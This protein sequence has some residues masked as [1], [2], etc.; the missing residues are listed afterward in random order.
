MRAGHDRVAAVLAGYNATIMAYGQTGSGK[1]HTMFGPDE[2]LSDFLSCDPELHGIVPRASEQLFEG[3]RHGAADS[4]FIVQCSYVEVYNDRLNDLLGSKQNLQ[5]RERPGAGIVVEGLVHEMVTGSRELMHQLAKGNAKRVVAAMKMNPRSSRGHAIFT[6]YVKEIL[7]YGGE[8][9][10]KLNLVD[11]AGMESSKKSYAMEGAS[12]HAMRKEEAKNINTSLYALGTVIE[13][14]SEAGKTGGKGAHVPYRDSKLTRLLQDSLGGNS[15][16]TIVV[17]LRIEAQNIEETTNTLRFAQRA[18]AVKTI[19][20]DNT[21][22]VKDTTKLLRE[23][24][25]MTVQLETAQLMVR[26][27]KQE[28]SKSVATTKAR[29]CCE[30]GLN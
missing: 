20:K 25:E 3:L 7:A 26:Q 4:S 9:A 13:K 8:K 19:V 10:G 16:S 5:M 24:D 1:T 27:L 28:L 30:A 17:T 14:L 18:K 11:L 15:K 23:I 2:V 6:V 21:I 29:S 22:S 12:N